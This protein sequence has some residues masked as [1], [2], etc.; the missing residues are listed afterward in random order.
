MKAILNFFANLFKGRQEPKVEPKVEP[1]PVPPVSPVVFK[2]VPKKELWYPPATR[3]AKPMVTR[4]TYKNHYP[5]GAVV[6]FTAGHWGAGAMEGGV[7]SGYAYLLIDENGKVYQANS[8][9]RWGYHA[10]AS[11][12]PG[13]GSGVSEHLVGIEIS[14]AGNV[15][16]VG[17][18]Y[19][20][21]FKTLL[22]EEQIRKVANKD[23]VKE[24]Y[25]QKYT[26][27]Q[28][29]ELIDLLLWLKRN[30]PDVFSFDLVVGHDEVA[31]T[32][33]TD[34]GG[35]LSCT[36]PEFRMKLKRLYEEAEK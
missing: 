15:V 31:P 24:G 10:G 5:Q 35:A 34:P 27:A 13:L 20:T 30:N 11:S 3:W 22:P 32:R 12:W 9:D 28:E 1:K 21:W 4:G 17:D 26:D 14:A 2:S 25:Y 23:N 7:T 19:Q 29:K 16:K 8:L 18:K 36:M 33:K 6:H